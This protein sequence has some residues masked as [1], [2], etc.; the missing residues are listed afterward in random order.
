MRLIERCFLVGKQRAEHYGRLGADVVT[1][2]GDVA[3]WSAEAG[4]AGGEQRS[5]RAGRAGEAVLEIIGGIIGEHDWVI[6]GRV[7]DAQPC[8]KIAVL[9]FAGFKVN[10]RCA[11][12]HGR[13]GNI[14]AQNIAVK[15]ADKVVQNGRIRFGRRDDR[16]FGC[17]RKLHSGSQRFVLRRFLIELFLPAENRQQECKQANKKEQHN[18]FDML[19]L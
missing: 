5:Q 6:D 17:L 14:F 2:D 3:G 7:R 16:R 1:I 11:D 18:S 9:R 10:A 8:G 13:C 19:P 15:R 4:I 12:R